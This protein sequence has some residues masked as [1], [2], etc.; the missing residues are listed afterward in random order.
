MEMVGAAS[1]RAL[2]VG[3]PLRPAP[4]T[5]KYGHPH[6]TITITNTHA[7]IPAT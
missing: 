2:R 4:P 5:Y 7:H 6:P 3:A 1:T